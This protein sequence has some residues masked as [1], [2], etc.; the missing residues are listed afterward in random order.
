MNMTGSVASPMGQMFNPQ[1]YLPGPQVPASHVDIGRFN[2]LRIVPVAYTMLT[3]VVQ[4]VNILDFNLIHLLQFQHTP[5][6]LLESP[7]KAAMLCGLEICLQAQLSSISRITSPGT[8]Q[9]TLRAH[10]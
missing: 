2:I 7:S 4:Q 8:Q 5:E 9:E 6:D 10:F 3:I 1:R